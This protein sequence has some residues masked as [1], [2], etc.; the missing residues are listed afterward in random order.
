[1]SA[2]RD[3]HD[4]AFVPDLEAAFDDVLG[5]LNALRAADFVPSPDSLTT[6]KDGYDE[7][8]WFYFDLH[9][10]G[11]FELNRER[12]PRTARASA[13]V[14]GMVNAGFSLLRPGTHLYPHR[15][16]MPNV[17]RCHLALRVP[18]GDL[19]LCIGGETRVWTAGRCLVFDDTIEHEAWNH[20]GGDRVALIVTFER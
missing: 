14:P 2:F 17:L 10:N 7:T 3:P 12:C 16:Q 13:A 20:T 19:G 18:S 11:D 15:G 6:V 4:F 9:G 8:G 1:V 5:E